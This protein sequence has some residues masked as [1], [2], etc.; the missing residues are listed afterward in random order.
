M[1]DKSVDK[2]IDDLKERSKE[3]N[4]LY[5]VEEIK[6]DPN[7]GLE[8]VFRRIVDTLPAG[9]QFSEICQAKIT[10]G[11]FEAQTEGFRET[12]WEQHADIVVQDE[13][14]G[15]IR[16]CYT[17]ERPQA[18]EG[19][20]LKEERKLIN[21]IADRLKHR[22]LHTKLKTVFERQRREGASH[23]EWEVILDL[24]RRT[25]PKLL[26]RIS[27]KMLNHLSWAGYDRAHRILERISPSARLDEDA[28]ERDENRP[29]RVTASQDILSASED[30]FKLA[31]MHLPE[32]EIL[33]FIQKWI[34]EDR[35][36]FLIKV[37]ENSNS[38]LA[39]IAS[40]IERYR[41]L[42]PQEWSCRR[43]G[44]GHSGFR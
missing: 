1:E 30:I 33:A 10:Y 26:M 2:L 22:I 34:K 40:A 44:S 28:P 35:S 39:E 17:D 27:R 8:E 18:D 14:V 32:Q 37:L 23:E 12:L 41:H 4:C 29:L 25:D 21:T 3:L 31:K 36:G 19:P 5:E 11:D 38:S 13:V 43:R 20:F 16:V 9:W 24:L 42:I 7:L 6:S 15:R